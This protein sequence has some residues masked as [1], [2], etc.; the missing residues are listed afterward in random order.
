MNLHALINR[1]GKHERNQ[2]RNVTFG[3]T[4]RNEKRNLRWRF[5]GAIK[6]I[7]DRDTIR[8]TFAIRRVRVQERDNYIY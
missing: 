5:A 3:G 7:S 2:K 1:W 6:E 8:D 4:F